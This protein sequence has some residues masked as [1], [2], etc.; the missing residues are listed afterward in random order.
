M[1]RGLTLSLALLATPVLADSIEIETSQGLRQS[2]LL[3]RQ[4]LFLTSPRWIRWMHWG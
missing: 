3:L 2:R 4:S 1:I